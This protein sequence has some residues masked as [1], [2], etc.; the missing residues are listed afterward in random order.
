M[1]E[2]Y[3]V[4]T[5]RNLAHACTGRRHGLRNLLPGAFS[6]GH[7]AH[8]LIGQQL[9]SLDLAL[10]VFNFLLTRQHTCLLGVGGIKP[11]AMAVDQVPVLHHI[12]TTCWQSRTIIQSFFNAVAHIN[13]GKPVVQQRAQICIA[14]TQQCS[15]R[16]HACRRSG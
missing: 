5:A 16:L 11:N 15:Q 14:D 8:G 1:L 12:H 4:Q 2:L 7:L 3:V 13:V 9:M 10:Q 6:T